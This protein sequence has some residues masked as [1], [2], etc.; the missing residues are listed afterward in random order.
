M[1]VWPLRMA[2]VLTLG[3]TGTVSP[4]L[5]SLARPFPVEVLQAGCV[6][7]PETPPLWGGSE[8][9][10][11]VYVTYL[12]IYTYLIRIQSYKTE[13]MVQSVLSV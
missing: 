12:D 3:P 10:T 5:K 6:S 9:N 4:R 2:T 13:S 1:F 7:S 11:H 8:D